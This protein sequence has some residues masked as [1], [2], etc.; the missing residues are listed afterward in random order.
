[1]E[2]ATKLV[3]NY[4]GAYDNEKGKENRKIQFR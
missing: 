4:G 1:M 2:F 3:R